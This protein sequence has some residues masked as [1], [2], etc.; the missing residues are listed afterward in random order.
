MS[1]IPKLMEC[2]IGSAIG[3]EWNIKGGEMEWKM[4]KWKLELRGFSV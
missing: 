2:V 3:L 1:A 4:R